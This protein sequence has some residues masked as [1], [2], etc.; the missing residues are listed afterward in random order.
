M[1]RALLLAMQHIIWQ[2]LLGG[3][4][5]SLKRKLPAGCASAA[6]AVK[7]SCQPTAQSSWTPPPVPHLYQQV[8]H[9]RHPC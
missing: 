3:N 6:S 5:N 4:G 7:G 2:M 8:V 9:Q 1:L